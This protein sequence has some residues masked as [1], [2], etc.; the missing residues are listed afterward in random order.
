MLAWLL[1]NYC[2][3][4]VKVKSENLKVK[5]LRGKETGCFLTF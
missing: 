1:I 5:K 4:L 3:L 2:I